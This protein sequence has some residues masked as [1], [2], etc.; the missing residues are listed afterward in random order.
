MKKDSGW[1]HIHLRTGALTLASCTHH[2]DP[3]NKKQSMKYRY[4]GSP[5]VKKFKTLSATKIMLTIFWDTSGVLYTTFL[6]KVLK[7]NSDW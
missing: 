1:L 2:Y 7:V 4:P 6:T 5:R 3:E